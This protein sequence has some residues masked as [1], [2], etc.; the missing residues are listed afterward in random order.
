MR[1]DD[2]DSFNQPWQAV[3]RYTSGKKSLVENSCAE[4]NDI[5]FNYGT[6]KAGKPDF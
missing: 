2:P 4:N 3:K 5:L 6:P 1:V